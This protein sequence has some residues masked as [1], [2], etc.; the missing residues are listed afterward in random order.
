MTRRLVS[1]VVALAAVVAVSETHLSAW[2]LKP[3]GKIWDAGVPTIP[4]VLNA[5]LD[6]LCVPQG[7]GSSCDTL[8]DVERTIKVAIDS[9][10]DE[11][12]ADIRLR[13][14][15]TTSTIPPGDPINGSIHIYA[16]ELDVNG[17]S[18]ADDSDSD[19]DIDRCRVEIDI[20]S[21]FNAYGG[22][23]VHTVTIH[24]I[25]HCLGFTHP[26]F[27][28]NDPPST[29]CEPWQDVESVVNTQEGGEHQLMKDDI[30]G[31]QTTYG[32]R[33]WE[34]GRLY[35]S[36]NGGQ[37]WT[38]GPGAPSTIDQARPRYAA[39][40]DV[41]EVYLSYPYIGIDS[42][43]VRVAR[44]DTAWTYLGAIPNATSVYHTGMAA[45]MN[46]QYEDDIVVSWWTNYADSTGAQELRAI[47]S[48]DGVP[49][50][51]PV[52]TPVNDQTKTSGVTGA[53]DPA[54]G[55]N[56]PRWVYFWRND[57]SDVMMAVYNPPLPG[58]TPAPPTLNVFPMN[59]AGSPIKSADSVGF[60][61]GPTS[62]LGTKNCM[63]T[64]TTHQWDHFFY[65]VVGYIS[66]GSFTFSDSDVYAHP[67]VVYGQPS[68]AYTNDSSYHLQ[69]TYHQGVYEAQD[70]DRGLDVRHP[71][72]VLRLHCESRHSTA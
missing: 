16:W 33:L 41:N 69:I 54:G 34:N 63:L 30:Q 65:W 68:V 10:N 18:H 59:F 11:A 12:G 51:G 52:A 38:L 70:G 36:T 46:G 72:N 42:S 21:A 44:W 67:T 37:T 55:P 27:D 26:R 53:F 64:W 58:Q 56:Q 48:D 31:L 19:G 43:A 5:N 20:S 60:A 15:S 23:S 35:K 61:C 57:N 45:R 32:V 9:F 71:T 3:D 22:N 14:S 8:A 25:M 28:P 17:Q 62:V 4:V 39:A 50:W 24:E 13:Y 6:D 66:G 40:G 2:C 7:G 49:T 1:I 47:R 29:H